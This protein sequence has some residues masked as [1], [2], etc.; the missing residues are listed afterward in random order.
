V[1]RSGLEVTTRI[2]AAEGRAARGREDASAK[3][4]RPSRLTGTQRQRLILDAAAELFAECGYE[5]AR[6]EEIAAAAGVSKA[7]IYEREAED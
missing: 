1:E 2:T 3:P 7:L 4:G 5:R 6:L